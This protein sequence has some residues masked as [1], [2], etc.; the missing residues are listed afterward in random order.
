[1]Y[2]NFGISGG[3]KVE[4]ATK[5]FVIYCRLNVGTQISC[6]IDN[7]TKFLREYLKI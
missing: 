3:N 7:L 6:L 5:I 2:R 1:M 4:E